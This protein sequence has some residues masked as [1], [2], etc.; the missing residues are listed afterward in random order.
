MGDAGVGENLR[1]G[2]P[3]QDPPDHLGLGRM[4]R[5]PDWR[6][7][8]GEAMRERVSRYYNKRVID[9]I[10]GDLYRDLLNSAPGNHLRK[11][12]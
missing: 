4:V 12:V 1:V 6:N 2:Q 10:Y 3:P 8:C 5:D 9:R 7:R 11:S